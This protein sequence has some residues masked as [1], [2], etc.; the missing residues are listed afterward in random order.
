MHTARANDTTLQSP[1]PIQSGEEADNALECFFLFR[2]INVFI[3]IIC[4]N[5]LQH[6]N[7]LYAQSN[8]YVFVDAVS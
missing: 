7:L 3:I 8:V 1:M 6:F 5:R 4:P 2:S